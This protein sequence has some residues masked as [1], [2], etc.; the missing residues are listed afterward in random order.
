MFVVCDV[1][2]MTVTLTSL[3]VWLFDV[4]WGDTGLKSFPALMSVKCPR[5]RLLIVL[6]VC[7]TYCRPHFEQLIKYTA[8][9]SGSCNNL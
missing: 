8:L 1:V 5:M 6:P 7:P 4:K 2:V 9:L 3:T